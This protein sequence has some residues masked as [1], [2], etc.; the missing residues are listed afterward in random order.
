M[1]W[2]RQQNPNGVSNPA[3]RPIQPDPVDLETSKQDARKQRQALANRT[4]PAAA[5]D[6]PIAAN[7]RKADGF[8]PNATSPGQ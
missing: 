5:T 6:L 3:I 2:S 4:V 7:A 8:A 1:A